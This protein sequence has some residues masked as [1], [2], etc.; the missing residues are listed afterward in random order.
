MRRCGPPIGSRTC[1]LGNPAKFRPG[2][3]PHGFPMLRWPKSHS[4]LSGKFR[5]V[6]RSGTRAIQVLGVQANVFPNWATAGRNRPYVCES[7]SKLVELGP[8][9]VGLSRNRAKCARIW[10]NLEERRPIWPGIGFD[11]CCDQTR[12]HFCPGSVNA[13]PN[14]TSFGQQPPAVGQHRPE[15]GRMLPDFDQNWP[16]ISHVCPDVGQIDATWG[17]GTTI[18]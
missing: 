5:R 4:P 9:L 11:R 1:G 14:S 13:R 8:T 6:A 16:G 10:D 2:V 7:G 17:G 15:L 18:I 3:E 12:P